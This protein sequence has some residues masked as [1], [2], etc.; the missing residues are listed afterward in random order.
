MS[1]K[2]AA[3]LCEVRLGIIGVFARLELSLGAAP[4]PDGGEARQRISV[5]TLPRC[6]VLPENGQRIIS[7]K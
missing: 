5:Q 4:T 7:L 1:Q 3:A 2:S 6:Q